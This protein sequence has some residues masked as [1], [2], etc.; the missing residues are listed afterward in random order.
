MYETLLK[1]AEKENV[2]VISLP[3]R[4][5][6]K[7][8]YCDGVIAINKSLS[9]TA[10]KTCVLAEELGHYHTSYG[11]IIDATI[12]VNR[13]QEVR[14]KRWAVNRLV[15]LKKIIKAYEAGCRNFYEI[16]EYLGITEKFLIESFNTYN[17][18]YGKYKVCGQY[19]IYFEPP[20][21]Y[22]NI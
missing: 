11:N 13:K 3:L 17:H 12:T 9:T 22:K 7:G 4:G 8:L 18:M 21:V 20:G 2:E 15:P 1:E 5:R 14:A 16:A 6:I 10:E 19:T